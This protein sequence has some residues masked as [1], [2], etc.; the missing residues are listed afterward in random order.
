MTPQELKQKVLEKLQVTAAGEDSQPED[1]QRVGARYE[2]L[3]NMLNSEG[4]VS[5]A[6]TADIPDF[7]EI[8]L[9]AMLSCHCAKEFGVVGQAYAEL[10]AEGGMSLPQMSWAERQFRRLMARKYVATRQ[11]SE[12][13]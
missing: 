10:L 11:S 4:L 3:Y 5:W 7:V 8:P 9:T 1:I 6:V 2:S 12:Y 13:F